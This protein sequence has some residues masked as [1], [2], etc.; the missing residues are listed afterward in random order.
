MFETIGVSTGNCLGTCS[1]FESNTDPQWNASIERGVVWV[2]KPSV[3]HTCKW[4]SVFAE[5]GKHSVY[6][7]GTVMSV[8]VWFVAYSADGSRLARGEGNDEESPHLALTWWF[9]ML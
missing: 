4:T 6:E 8:P 2:K 7:S 3:Q 1:E 9:A 5:K